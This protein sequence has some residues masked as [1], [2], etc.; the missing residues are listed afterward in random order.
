MGIIEQTFRRRTELELPQVECVWVEIN[1][2]HKKIL[3]G[4][5]YRPPS[6]LGR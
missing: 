4:A 3:I 1:I 5:I 2:H 6:S